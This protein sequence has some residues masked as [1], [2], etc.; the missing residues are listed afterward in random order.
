MR[1]LGD[2][3]LSNRGAL[4]NLQGNAG[5]GT[6]N[7]AGPGG[8]IDLADGASVE[9]PYEFTPNTHGP[10]A[11]TVGLTFT[12]GNLT[13]NNQAYNVNV[14]LL[15]VG[16]GPELGTPRVPGSLIDFGV[17]ESGQTSLQSLAVRNDTPDGNLGNVT[18]LTLLNAIIAG[19]DASLF[20]LGLFTPG[21]VLSAAEALSLDLVLNPQG[22][23]GAFQATLQLTTDQG[24]AL[25]T[26]GQLFTYQLVG[27]S[28]MTVLGI[29]T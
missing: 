6:G 8:S 28:A 18:N 24:A 11:A 19:P 9:F 1:N 5:A 25:G 14:G 22:Q 12:N 29:S 27:S 7:F 20:S 15:G 26:T 4:S 3:N 13:G 16:V 10:Q 2:G 17:V 21:T 23:A